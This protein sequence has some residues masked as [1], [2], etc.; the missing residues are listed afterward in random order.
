MCRGH[1]SLKHAVALQPQ[2]GAV[3]QP[4]GGYH[5][6]KVSKFCASRDPLGKKYLPCI[7][8]LALYCTLYTSIHD[9]CTMF[10]RVHI[11]TLHQEIMPVALWISLSLNRIV[12]SK[13]ALCH[14]FWKFA[15]KLVL[16]GQGTLSLFKSYT[17]PASEDAPENYQCHILKVYTR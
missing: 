16:G 8:V 15:F 14:I 9:H 4:I 11:A 10:I 17:L 6:R 1:L 3:E 13:V 7:L 2:G 5:S 12:L